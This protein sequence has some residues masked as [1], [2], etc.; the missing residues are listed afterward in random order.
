M[1]ERYAGHDRGVVM[2][3]KRDRPMTTGELAA[4]APS[5]IIQD[6]LFEFA[7]N[8]AFAYI[9][10]WRIIADAIDGALAEQAAAHERRVAEL[11]HANNRELERRVGR[12]EAALASVLAAKKEARS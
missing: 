3:Q 9:H 5:V 4:R 1:T 12:P 11:L 10:C 6:R 2:L 8:Y 7:S